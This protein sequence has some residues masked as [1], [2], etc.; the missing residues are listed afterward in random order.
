MQ[1]SASVHINSRGNIPIP[2]QIKQILHFTTDTELVM[3]VEDNI[4]KIMSREQAIL[5]AQQLCELPDEL[6]NESFVQ[7]LREERD[8]DDK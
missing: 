2:E 7:R 1:N 5:E 3:F 6:Q 4:L 8:N